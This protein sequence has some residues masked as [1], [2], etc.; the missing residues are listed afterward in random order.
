MFGF[1]MVVHCSMCNL[2]NYCTYI[3]SCGQGKFFLIDLTDQAEKGSD[4]AMRTHITMAGGGFVGMNK[5]DGDSRKYCNYCSCN[6]MRS[7]I[8]IGH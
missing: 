8:K 1:E 2:C 3:H 5:E 7:T 4:A 6:V